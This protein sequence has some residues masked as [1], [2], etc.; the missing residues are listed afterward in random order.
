MKLSTPLV[1]LL[2]L[3]F[4][5]AWAQQVPPPPPPLDSANF[6]NKVFTKV[7]IEAM[8][9]GGDN[10]WRSFLTKNLNPNTPVDNGAPAG[11]YTVIVKFIVSKSGAL[12]EINAET[13][14]GYGMEREVIRMISRSGNWTP[15]Y[16][17]KKAVNAYRRQPVT[18]LVEEDGFSINTKVPYTLHTGENLVQVEAGKK[19]RGNLRLSISQGSI[20]PTDDEGYYKVRLTEPGR[21]IIT[22]YNSKTDKKIGDASFEVVKKD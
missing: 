8:Y 20:T 11:K 13:N 14:M 9:P 19:D 10:A 18:F 1:V 3:G 17:N 15:A 7:D 2:L 12:T 16:Q 4:S 22:L 5:T 6:D 21:V